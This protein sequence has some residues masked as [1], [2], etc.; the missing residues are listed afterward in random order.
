MIKRFMRRG[1]FVVVALPSLLAWVVVTTEA[2]AQKKQQAVDPERLKLA[3]QLI[4]MSGVRKVH[5][6]TLQSTVRRVIEQHAVRV[7]A[8]HQ[9]AYRQ[10]MSRYEQELQKRRPRLWDELTAVYAR[11]LTGEELRAM[12]DF[13]ATPVGAAIAVKLP[14]ISKQAGEVSQAILL[15]ATQAY[16]K[17]LPQQPQSAATKAAPSASKAEPKKQSRTKRQLEESEPTKGTESRP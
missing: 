7:P 13:H 17:T 6:E 1:I 8:E 3:K 5:E 12:L 2:S 11:N 9:A 15:E 10:L 16:L 14:Q 4:D